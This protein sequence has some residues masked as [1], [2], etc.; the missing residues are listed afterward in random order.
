MPKELL[1]KQYHILPRGI[2]SPSHNLLPRLSR[3]R[4]ESREKARLS[5]S[6]SEE[7]ALPSGK[8]AIAVARK[9]DQE[10]E[11]RETYR[12][13]AAMSAP[14]SPVAMQ[15]DVRFFPCIVCDTSGDLA[16]HPVNFDVVNNE[17]S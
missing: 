17:P 11:E 15:R 7:R 10:M 12:L 6:Y 13:S 9:E 5:R 4:R 8:W 3:E 2:A 16:D 1:F 14:A